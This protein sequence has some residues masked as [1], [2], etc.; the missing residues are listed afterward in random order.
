MSYISMCY[1]WS[2]SSIVFYAFIAAIYIFFPTTKT[3][4]AGAQA[5]NPPVTGRTPLPLLLS[6]KIIELKHKSVFI[7]TWV[8]ANA[9]F[10]QFKIYLQ[11]NV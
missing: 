11:S 3:D 9:H 1:M 6:N 4:G 10:S 2:V 7:N 5:A 8:N